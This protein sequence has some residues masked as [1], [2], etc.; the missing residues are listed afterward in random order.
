MK[1]LNQNSEPSPTLSL[2]R[3]VRSFFTCPSDLRA[4]SDCAYSIRNPGGQAN[5]NP[6]LALSAWSSYNR[7]MIKKN[8]TKPEI[9]TFSRNGVPEEVLINDVEYKVHRLDKVNKI[10]ILFNVIEARFIE[11][12][13]KLIPSLA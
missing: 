12:P 7:R 1:L 10:A 6:R 4:F 9:R 13:F 3:P 5:D 8:T 2:S 11:V